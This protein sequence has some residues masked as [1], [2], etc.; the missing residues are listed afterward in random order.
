MYGRNWSCCIPIAALLAR[1]LCE[2]YRTESLNIGII[3]KCWKFSC[4][5]KVIKLVTI[6]KLNNYVH[7][8]EKFGPW[9]KSVIMSDKFE[10]HILGTYFADEMLINAV[11][12]YTMLQLHEHYVCYLQ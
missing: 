10:A 6:V 3:K 11:Y 8:R 12:K 7:V 4:R 5:L 9:E 2:H 1:S